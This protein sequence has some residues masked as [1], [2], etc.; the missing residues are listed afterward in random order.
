MGGKIGSKSLKKASKTPFDPK[1]DP[2]K[3]K[4]EPENL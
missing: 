3:K 2:N 4:G 1:V